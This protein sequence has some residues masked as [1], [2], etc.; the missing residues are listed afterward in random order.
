MTILG[1]FVPDLRFLACKI[2]ARFLF[3]Y[4]FFFIRFVKHLSLYIL[5]AS[6]YADITESNKI[7]SEWLNNI[8]RGR[9]MYQMSAAPESQKQND[10]RVGA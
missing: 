2:F 3:L 5:I 1:K 6:R 4:F 9:L 7:L 8:V 10:K